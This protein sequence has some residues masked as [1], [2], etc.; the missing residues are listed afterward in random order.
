MSSGTWDAP[1]DQHAGFRLNRARLARGIPAA[2]A[3]GGCSL[4]PVLSHI[5]GQAGTV[6]TR[7]KESRYAYFRQHRR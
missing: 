7:G 4:E 5:R 2:R 1:P 6:S 3:I